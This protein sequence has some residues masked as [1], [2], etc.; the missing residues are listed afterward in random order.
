M[1]IYESVIDHISQYPSV[2]GN[3]VV[4]KVQLPIAKSVDDF[5]KPRIFGVLRVFDDGGEAIG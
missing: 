5:V 1:S 4:G 3:S 2:F